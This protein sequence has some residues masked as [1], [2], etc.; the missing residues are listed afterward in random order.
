[1]EAMEEEEGGRGR[2][3]KRRWRLTF[4]GQEEK[5]VHVGFRSSSRGSGSP[6]DGGKTSGGRRSDLLGDGT[7]SMFGGVYVIFVTVGVVLRQ[8]ERAEAMPLWVHEEP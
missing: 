7:V 1:M 3:R 6:R 8:A 5:W 2:R 4:D